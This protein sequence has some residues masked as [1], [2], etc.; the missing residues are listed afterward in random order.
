MRFGGSC[1]PME[2]GLSHWSC[3]ITQCILN[4]L[5]GK[6]AGDPE[7]SRNQTG[8]TDWLIRRTRQLRDK[9]EQCMRVGV[10]DKVWNL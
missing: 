10:V 7:F 8:L 3:Q 2:L 5:C 6:D 9:M 1:R 4:V